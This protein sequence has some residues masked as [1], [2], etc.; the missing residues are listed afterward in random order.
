[1][2]RKFLPVLLCGLLGCLLA[3]EGSIWLFHVFMLYDDE[4]YVLVSLK[5]FS[6]HGSLYSQVYSQYGPAFYLVY[7]ALHR[8]LGFAWTNTTGRWITL[9]NWTGAAVFSALLVRRAR[10]S[11]PLVL[12]VLVEVFSFLRIMTSEPMHPGGTIALIVAATAWLG[13]ELLQV[14]RIDAFAFLTAAMGAVLAMMKINV[15]VFL[16]LSAVLWLALSMLPDRSRQY[17]WVLGIVGGLLPLALMRTRIDEDWA[18]VFAAVAGFS[19]L[20]ATVAAGSAARLRP[21]GP[22]TWLGFASTGLAVAAL[23]AGLILLRGTSLA[24]LW[25]GLIVGPLGHPNA[26]AFGPVWLPGTLWLAGGAVALLLLAC[27]FPE[28]R[29]LGMCLASMKIVAAIAWVYC[30][31]RHLDAYQGIAGLN[32][33][34]PLA[35]LFAWPLDRKNPASRPGDQAR[36][37]LAII[38]VFQALHAYPVAG[39]QLNWGTFLWVPLMALG[40]EDAV[41]VVGTTFTPTVAVRTCRAT[42]IIASLLAAHLTMNF[43]FMS[44]SL[45]ARKGNEPL[46]QPGAEHISVQADYSSAL[47]ILAENVRAHGDMLFSLP[48]SYSFNLWTGVGTPTLA[49]VT[50]WFSLLNDEQQQAIIRR[51]D[52]A[53][54]PVFIVQHAI[55]ADAVGS[56]VR[57]KGPLMDYLLS[58]F[59]RSFTI[60]S[61]SFWVPNGRSIAALSTGILTTSPDDSPGKVHLQLTVAP[62]ADKTTCVELWSTQGANERLL[63]LDASQTEVTLTPLRLDGTETGSPYVASWPWSNEQVAR[64]TLTF[65]P[66]SPLPP[67]NTIEVLFMNDEGNCTGTARILTGDGW[68]LGLE[69]RDAAADRP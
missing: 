25:Q 54:R 27:R 16:G 21:A 51:L 62:H 26:Y 6:L 35:G 8:L 29:R 39:S 2:I 67:P 59:H 50:H 44:L 47:R 20:G 31:I 33:G 12:C 18:R 57:P 34:V 40:F 65:T 10:G 4:G 55:L 68:K 49:N 37:W 38:L 15:G 3:W 42:T 14:D 41:R 45:L 61:Y 9:L 64:V 28:D 24:E 11:W 66:P 52:S 58:S 60:E 1:M 56:G 7:D 43:S 32:Y 46:A 13:W 63:T 19:I 22:R 48:G 17:A 69:N 53:D 30:I 36:G 23:I 5:N